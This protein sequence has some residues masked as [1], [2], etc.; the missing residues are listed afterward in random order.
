V[1]VVGGIIAGRISR[2][3]ERNAAEPHVRSPE[4]HD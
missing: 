3:K 1:L 2:Q 4:R